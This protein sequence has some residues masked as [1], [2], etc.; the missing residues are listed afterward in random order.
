[1]PLRY[2]QLKRMG[3]QGTNE[4]HEIWMKRAIRLARKGIG[5]THPNPRVGAVVVRHGEV[6]G[7]GWHRRAGEPHAEVLALAAAGN[8]ARGATLYVTLSRAR[9]PGARRPV[10]R[11]S[12]GPAFDKWCMPLP[13]RIHEWPEVPRC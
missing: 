10:R 11:R 6:V 13:I 7:T 2:R 4:S 3:K 8:R 1:M 9:Q 12:S 5:S